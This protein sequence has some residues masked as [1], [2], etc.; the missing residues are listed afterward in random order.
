MFAVVGGLVSFLGWA[1]D[2]PRL[3]DWFNNGIT[4]QPNTTVAVM[5][6]GAALLL[7]SLG[8]HRV[9]AALGCV[10]AL[11]GFI[12]FSQ[13]LFGFTLEP[14]NT[15]LMFGRTWGRAGVVEPGRMGPPGAFC[16]TLIGVALVLASGVWGRSR[17]RAVPILA[18]VTF[19]LSLF[20]I[21]G[22][23]YGATEFYSAPHL[24]VIA[25]QTAMFIF[26]VSMGLIGA[27]EE[28]GPMRLLTDRGPAGDI[29]RVATP[30]VFFV[31]F[32]IG[33]IRLTGERLGLYDTSTGTAG[34]TLVETGL[35]LG[36][37]AW[38]LTTMRRHDATL[39]KADRRK[40]EF[41]ATLAHEL[42]GPLAPLRNMLEVLKRTPGGGA[43]QER[44]QETMDRQLRHLV[45][46]VDDL[47][48]V[49]RITHGKL[50][51]RKEPVALAA[52]LQQAIETYQ[53]RAQ[54]M[55]IALNVSMPS[56]PVQVNG[57]A[58]RLVQVFGNI[59]HNA[60]NFTERGGTIA[61]VATRE[62]HSVIVRVRDTGEGIA[63]DRLE[64]IFEMFSQ[65]RAGEQPQGLGIGLTLVKRLVE[66]HGGRV[67]AVSAGQGKGT[68]IIV[69]LPRA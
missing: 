7:L 22:Y 25:L 40:N 11:L 10:V 43:V 3:G 58:V 67:R 42:R 62:N 28:F 63:P 18:M 13:Y 16:W 26:T 23:L 31:S 2:V 21:T 4:I 35:L 36:L 17:R 48:D 59:L 1:L 20:G 46:L 14:F 57:D 15:A 32:A 8:Y 33:L 34:R 29:A 65:I 44:A 30:A 51:L 49:N 55:G 5:C 52:V 50:E 27:V 47:I 69:Q 39:R 12:S 41:L 24:T 9:V 37:V 19:G 66:L 68:E 38:T 56:E 64:D 53:L 45:R 6:A 61:V 60:V 54:E